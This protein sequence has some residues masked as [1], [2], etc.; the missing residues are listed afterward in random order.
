MLVLVAA[1]LFSTTAVA[2]PLGYVALPVTCLDPTCYQY[3][4]TFA[5]V[6][7]ST[8]AITPIGTPEGF[9]QSIGGMAWLG[10]I[11]YANDA[12]QNSVYQ[13]DPATGNSMLK[14]SLNLAAGSTSVL[15]AS[16]GHLYELAL[17]TMDLYSFDPGTGNSTLVGP[18]GIP[19]LGFP[20][21]YSIVLAGLGSSLYADY[22]QQDNQQNPLVPDGFYRIDPTTGH[23]TLVGGGLSGAE[24]ISGLGTVGNNLYAAGF[25]TG[26]CGNPQG[27]G[28]YT[29]DPSTATATFVSTPSTGPIQAL[30]GDAPEPGGYILVGLGLAA[31]CRRRLLVTLWGSQSGLRTG[32]PAGTAG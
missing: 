10:N 2:G 7:F 31:L 6:D 26:M 14:G 29:I 30:T 17:P 8:G 32:F 24:C 21:L 20:N 22:L 28:F 9:V 23:A 25:N 16:L 5:A 15:G 13:V 3:T 4:T 11:L 19:F 18:T 12:F 27:A 1:G